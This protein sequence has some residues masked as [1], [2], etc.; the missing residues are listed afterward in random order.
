[1]IYRLQK[2]LKKSAAMKFDVCIH[3]YVY[4]YVYVRELGV[5]VCACM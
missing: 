2:H 4:V 3:M 5:S 1:M